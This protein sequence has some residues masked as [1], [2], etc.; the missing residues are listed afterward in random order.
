M[1]NLAENGNFDLWCLCSHLFCYLFYSTSAQIQFNSTVFL[2]V[3][4]WPLIALTF[5]H[6]FIASAHIVLIHCKLFFPRAFFSFPLYLIAVNPPWLECLFLHLNKTVV[7][8]LFYC[9]SCLHALMQSWLMN[10]LRVLNPRV[11]YAFHLNSAATLLPTH[12]FPDASRQQRSQCGSEVSSW[13]AK[14]FEKLVLPWLII[15][16]E[17]LLHSWQPVQLLKVILYSLFCS[18]SNVLIISI[19]LVQ[20]FHHI[21]PPPSRFSC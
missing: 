15:L 20:G 21:Y 9:L 7:I 8:L 19:H 17:W 13:W 11:S 1:W 5:N 12:S 4:I 3:Y 10:S 14:M 18:P 6:P 2:E 16:N